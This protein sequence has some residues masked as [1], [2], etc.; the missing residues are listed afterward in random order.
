MRVVG[1]IIG[2]AGLCIGVEKKIN[3]T[4]LLFA[5]VTVVN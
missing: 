4:G 2:L 5:L 3:A 1:K